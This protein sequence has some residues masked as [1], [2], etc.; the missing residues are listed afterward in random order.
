M[1]T[2]IKAVAAITIAFCIG[3]TTVAAQSRPPTA[4]A[5]AACRE[6]GGVAQESLDI[7]RGVQA[8][9]AGLADQRELQQRYAA[10]QQR[11]QRSPYGPVLIQAIGGDSGV[12][13]WIVDIRAAREASC[14]QA[15]TAGIFGNVIDR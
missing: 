9:R 4:N 3:V 6:Y 1:R 14:L 5:R 7:A 15:A 2:Y 13:P 8:T 11:V 12:P 10:L